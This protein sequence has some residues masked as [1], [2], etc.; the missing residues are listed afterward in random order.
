MRNSPTKTQIIMVLSILLIAYVWTRS[1]PSANY[2]L[3][4]QA[5]AVKA[6]SSSFLEREAGI[7]AYVNA[8]RAI[9]LT[10]VKDV[11]RT[12]EVQTSDYLIGS[13][14]VSN[15]DETE[16]VHAY[17]HKDG[18]ILVYYLANDPLSKIIDWRAY[19]TTAIPT[20]LEQALGTLASRVGVGTTNVAFY[21][22]RF[23]TATHLML[24][25]KSNDSFQVKLPDGFEYYQMGWSLA[26]D[27][28][29]VPC[30]SGSEVI[31][32]IDGSKLQLLIISYPESTVWQS[33]YGNLTGSQL[34]AG[35]YHTITAQT[36][37]AKSTTSFAGVAVIYK[38]Q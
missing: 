22:F 10:Q 1:N 11:F 15:Y 24:A 25:G 30:C 26:Q 33:I 23:P 21:D 12:L 34:S 3:P 28:K 38:E 13:V 6:Q 5:P 14:P 16:D 35:T 9:N 18:W 31:Y 37:D 4:L 27:A 20:K 19:N 7:S 17:V 32:Q 2:T 29:N 36:S 8:N